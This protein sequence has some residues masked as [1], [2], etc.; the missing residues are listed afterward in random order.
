MCL[1]HTYIPL[2]VRGILLLLYISFTISMIWPQYP[3]STDLMTASER[4]IAYLESVLTCG[5]GLG[6]GLGLRGFP[7]FSEKRIFCE[8]K[9]S[10]KWCHFISLHSPRRQNFSTKFQT[11]ASHDMASDRESR[12]DQSF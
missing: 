7:P 11:K 5:L 8:S 2:A 4:N 1:Y 3:R 6:L 12:S 10:V 9:I